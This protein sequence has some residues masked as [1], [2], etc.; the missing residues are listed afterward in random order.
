[1][2][3]NLVGF[4]F[5]LPGVLENVTAVTFA[6][7]PQ[8]RRNDLWK[9]S[10]VAVG[11]SAMQLGCGWLFAAPALQALRVVDADAVAATFRILLA[12]TSVMTMAGPALA[13]AMCFRKM[14][15]VFAKLFLPAAVV[16]ALAVWWAGRQWGADGAA[17]AHASVSAA[18][19]V[20]VM[21]YVWTGRDDPSLIEPATAE[22]ELTFQE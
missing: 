17:W 7:A 4:A 8:S 13:Y 22:A 12:G 6:H 3:I 21:I 11:L 18:A 9:F 2:A 14:R 5:I 15:S 20:A 16:F 19:G 10:G 1:V